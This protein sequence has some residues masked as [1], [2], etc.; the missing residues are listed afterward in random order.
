MSRHTLSGP[1]SNYGCEGILDE[2]TK[3]VKS[4]LD[5]STKAIRVSFVFSATEPYARSPILLATHIRAT[6]TFFT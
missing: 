4:P 3:T 2:K 6:P 5:K 1:P